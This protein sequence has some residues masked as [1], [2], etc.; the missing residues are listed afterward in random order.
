MVMMWCVDGDDQHLFAL[1]WSRKLETPRKKRT[2]AEK[3]KLKEV[4]DPFSYLVKLAESQEK[5]ARDETLHRRRRKK[6]AVISSGKEVS[7]LQKIQ[8][9]D[10]RVAPAT[11]PAPAPAPV[12][13]LATTVDLHEELYAIEI[14]ACD[15]QV[16]MAVL[17]K[18]ECQLNLRKCKLLKSNPKSLEQFDAFGFL[19]K[20]TK[21]FLSS[22]S[23]LS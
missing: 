1:S 9:E 17:L 19:D 23:T 3:E 14:E 10:R 16:Q 8:T 2:V 11:G 6:K 13:A 21:V 20:K 18:Q 4:K 12:P 7:H 5:R 22:L 15:I